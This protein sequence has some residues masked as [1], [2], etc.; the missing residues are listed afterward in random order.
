MAETTANS[1]EADG[2]HD[3]LPQTDGKPRGNDGKPRGNTAR[4]DRLAGR[5]KSLGLTQE[6]LAALLKVERST[7]AR[8]ERGETE[9]VPWLRPRLAKALRVSTDRLGELLDGTA[10]ASQDAGTQPTGGAGDPV[11][12]G[13]A[14]PGHANGPAFVSHAVPVRPRQL[15][16]TIADFAGRA[17]ELAALT[18]ILE[19][20]DGT[21]PGTV[22]ISAIGGTAGVG[23]T[24]VA[25]HWAHRI[26]DRFPDG[27]LHVNLRGFDPSGT[28]V[29]P[30]DAIRSF[31]DALGVPPARIPAGLDAQ[32]GLYRGLLADSRTLIMLDN[33]RDEEQVRPL[34]PASPGSLVIV[35]SRNQ[36][37]GLA[38]V[39]GARLL[40]LDVLASTEAIALLASRIGATRAAAEPE[41]IAEIAARC[42]CL[43][44]ALV[45][46]AARAAA[47][48]RFPLAALADELRDTATRLDALDVDDSYAS[49]RSIVS[50][51]Y[52]Q[53]DPATARMFRLLA[54]HPGPDISVPAA[55]SLAAADQA[56]ARRMLSSLARAH[57]ITEHVAGRYAFHDLLRTYAED[58]SRATDQAEE[59]RAATTRLL[60][61]YLHTAYRC[62]SAVRRVFR[63][64]DLTPPVPG[65][66]PE[67]PAGYEQA[68]SWLDAERLVLLAV[69]ALAD[70]SGFDRH[71]AQLPRVMGSYFVR[72]GR[73]RESA[74]TQNLAVA[75]AR[76]LG[77]LA[78]EASSSRLLGNAYIRLGDYDQALDCQTRSL[79]LYRRVGDRQGQ[80]LV[81]GGL[82][83]V[84]EYQGRYADALDHADQALGLYRALSDRL[85]E[86]KVLNAVGWFRALLGDYEQARERC[87]QAL[88]LMAELGVR[89][90]QAPVWDSLGYIEHRLGH[91]VEA[92]ACCE[93]ALSICREFSEPWNEAD[94]LT[95]LGDIRYDADDLTAARDAWRQA[96]DIMG[97]VDHP[98]ADS[99]RAKL[100]AATE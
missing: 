43:P 96:L 16:A 90:E 37:S 33:A 40:S 65:A 79:T 8:W 36:L 86:A 41:A 5:R 31:L 38:A 1:G 29:A 74:V 67:S 71:V 2:P 28:P 47:R 83:M 62:V 45:V 77:D 63:P 58:Q 92:A 6:D 70:S 59:R 44:L 22:L 49:V 84:A 87:R 27:Q 81:H 32:A 4:R 23:K 68:L 7:V 85:G 75:A 34:L 30:E 60:D 10:S 50:W 98:D 39:N 100:K 57:L 76:R 12:D 20:A 53:L 26:A 19:R 14:S 73:Y 93:R 99:V 72:R 91:L 56:S 42:A 89:E 15:P 94:F 82:S 9:P 64:P 17:A 35:T 13:G 88:A 69:I 24:T 3:G 46:A 52:Q 18:E 25:L 11:R 55:A 51:S 48:P 97:A 95:H 80:A 66:V 54:V 61:H 21:A 78:A